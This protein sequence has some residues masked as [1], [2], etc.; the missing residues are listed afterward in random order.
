M[1]PIC[2]SFDGAV[3]YTAIDSKPKTVAPTELAR[4]KNIRATPQVALLIDEYDEDWAR[5]WFV[6]I[7]G[8][9]ELISALQER[10]SA[11]AQL[12]AKYPQYRSGMLD[13]AAPILRITPRRVTTWGNL[14]SQDE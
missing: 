7:R 12:R 3:F 13:H 4:V 5:L 14:D 11:L 1:V 9:A 6:L 10:Q 8:E 2:F